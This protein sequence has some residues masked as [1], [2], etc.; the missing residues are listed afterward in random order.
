MEVAIMP[1]SRY[2]IPPSAL[3]RRLRSKATKA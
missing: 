2:F 1:V 3:S